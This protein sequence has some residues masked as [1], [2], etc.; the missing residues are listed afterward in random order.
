MII[1]V[2]PISFAGLKLNSK[3]NLK[4]KGML[5]CLLQFYSD[6]WS[7]WSYKVGYFIYYQD[8]E[9]GKNIPA[10]CVEPSRE[11]VGELGSYDTTID[12][13]NDNGI[14]TILYLYNNKKYTD[15]ELQ[16]AEDYYLAAQT[17]MHCYADKV[18]PKD[19]YRVGDRVLEGYTP[20]S[21][22]EIK[23][24]GKVVLNTAQSLYDSAI[25][26][27]YKQQDL[28]IG[29]EERSNWK[30]E[31]ISGVKYYCKEY[32]IQSN[33]DLE[34]YK[35]DALGVSKNISIFTSGNKKINNNGK[36]E[37]E[38]F[39][40][41]IPKDEFN[42]K[43]TIKGNIKVTAVSDKIPVAVYANSKSSNKQNYAVYTYEEQ[44]ASISKNME[45]AIDIDKLIINKL[46]FF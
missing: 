46:D 36:I 1:Q 24:R 10:L 27:E 40:I 22:D 25:K 29:I 16:N 39:K 33:Y 26:N 20:N 3:I 45:L 43:T 42:Y 13:C 38:N 34:F 15:W 12:V 31:K 5:D 19:R 9:L 2:T 35:V 28:K 41:A 21:L 6:E 32:K 44:Q 7:D 23:Q 8:E 30:E 17:A 18:K 4:S 14:Y 37:Y 11:G